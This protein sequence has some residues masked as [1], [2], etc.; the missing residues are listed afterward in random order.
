[1]LFSARSA[2]LP[3]LLEAAGATLTHTSFLPA[4]LYNCDMCRGFA[5]LP[6]EWQLTTATTTGQND[7]AAT[8]APPSDY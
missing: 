8:P 3:G 6:A 2:L 5:S 1:M 7:A 4:L